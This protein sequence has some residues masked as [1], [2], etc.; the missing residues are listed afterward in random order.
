MEKIRLQK[1][2]ADAGISSRRKAEELIEKGA[3]LVNGRRAKLGEKADPSKDK[4]TVAGREIKIQSNAKKYYIMLHKPRGYIT[5][6]SD[7]GGR[8]CVTEL[9]EEVPARLFHVGRLD[10]ESEGLLLMTNDADFAKMITHPSTHFAKTYRVTVRPRVTEEQLTK[11]TTGVVIDGRESLPASVRV[12]KGEQDRTVLEIVLEEGRNRQIRKMCE[13]VG[14]EVA[15]LKRTAIGPV[16]LGML[17]PGKWREL[18]NEEMRMIK[19]YHKKLEAK[20]V[21]ETHDRK[22]K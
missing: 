13:A 20:K 11:L 22:K 4:I 18:T 6:A 9:V 21:N 14:L 3:V 19:T 8:K 15:R 12:V 10:R 17:Q 2:I 16:K 1:S 5:T 7:E